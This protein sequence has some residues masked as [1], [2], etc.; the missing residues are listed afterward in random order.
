[1]QLDEAFIGA[2]AEQ[3]SF[4]AFALEPQQQSNWC[5]AAIAVSLARYYGVGEFTQH[6][7]ALAVLGTRQVH[8]EQVYG[9]SV[10]PDRFN[11]I[12]LL[13]DALQYVGCRASWTPGRPELRDIVAEIAA[14]RPVCACLQWRT[15]D[16]HYVVLTGC[17]AETGELTVEDPLQVHSLQKF[18]AFP[19]V[20]RSAG[21][22]WRGVYWTA[23]DS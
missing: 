6:Q 21:T 5:W 4:I 11:T 18:D 3:S 23:P 19:G 1:M 15:G 22:V 8:E 9:E 12:A 13:E 16:A 10:S 20:Y 14:G 2:S 17:L 7:V